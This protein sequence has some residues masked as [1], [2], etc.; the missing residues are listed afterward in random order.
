MK[1]SWQEYWSGKLFPSP[2]D[3]P[4]AGIK[5]GSPVLQA[6]SLLSEPLGKPIYVCI[7][8]HTHTFK[9][10]SNIFFWLTLVLESC[11]IL[12]FRVKTIK[13]GA[14]REIYLYSSFFSIDF[15]P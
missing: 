3:L 9:F 4:G 1:F 6:D 11:K 15:S 5:S 8:T 7:H 2:G 14:F 12:G 13:Q 10:A